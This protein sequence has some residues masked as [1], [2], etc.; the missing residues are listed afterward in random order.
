MEIEDNNRK[1][2]KCDKNILLLSSFFFKN[3]FQ[4]EGKN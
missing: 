3:T 4:I 1:L 2:I